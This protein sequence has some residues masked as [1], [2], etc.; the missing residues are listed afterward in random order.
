MIDRSIPLE[1]RDICLGS[2]PEPDVT[3]LPNG[4]TLHTFASGNV[5]VCR[6]SVVIQGGEAEAPSA[7]LAKLSAQMLTEGAGGMTGAEVAESLDYNGAWITSKSDSHH[8]SVTLFSLTRNLKPLLP[9]ISDMVFMPRFDEGEFE[10]Y[11]ERMAQALDTDLTKPS[12]VAAKGAECAF[13]GHGHPFSREVSP[14]DIRRLTTEAAAEFHRTAL[15]GKNIHV[16]LAGNFDD[17]LRQEIADFWGAVDAMESGHSLLLEPPRITADRGRRIHIPVS[18]AVQSAINIM[19]PAIMR[20]D[21]DY[22]ALRI[23]V[24]GLGGYFGSRL[25]AN[26]REDKGMTYGISASLLGYHEAGAVS[27]T[28]QAD[29]DY[30]DDVVKEV[31]RELDRMAS[32]DF[33][34]DELQRLRNYVSLVLASQLDSPFSI[35]DYHESHITAGTPADYFQRQIDALKNLDARRIAELSRR[36]LVPSRMVVVTAG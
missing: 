23:T 16:F 6:L 2:M 7:P 29:A 19:I 27:I 33:S 11:R 22:E 25:M 35:I 10:V 21:P 1:V 31:E 24:I 34:T 12:Y 15:N 13:F 28:T 32:G 9:L 18:G 17:R 30:V 8:R 14:Q 26:I 4:I 36:Y 3:V 5:G 20:T